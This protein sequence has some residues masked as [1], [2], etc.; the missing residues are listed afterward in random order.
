MIA[1]VLVQKYRWGLPFHRQS[2][3]AR[4]RG[5][6]ARRR[7]DVP[8][9][10]GRGRHARVHR[11]RVRQ[12]GQGDGV[13]PVDRRHRRV[14]PARAARRTAAP[15]LSQ[16]ALLRR[17]RRQGPRL[18][19]VSAQAHER[20][21]LRDVPRILRLHPGRRPRHLRRG[22]PRRG[23]DVATTTRLPRRWAAGATAGERPG[24]RPSSRKT[25]R[26][27]RRS[28]AC[29]R[30]SSSKS[31]GRHW[32]PRS[33]TRDGSSSSRPLVDDFFAWAAAQ[34]ARVKDTRGLVATAFGYAVRQEAALRRFLDDG[35]LPMTNNHSERALQDHRRRS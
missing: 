8:L 32:P 7:H 16:G 26:R 11:R 17:A 4:G 31:S 35:R 28:C 13:L 19:R 25:R 20:R 10:R 5:R 22:L 9:R 15:G 18:L 12:G 21:R 33:G 14:H 34:Y 2:R 29:A 30:S 1:H 24:K 6:Q 27:A 23:A 3:D